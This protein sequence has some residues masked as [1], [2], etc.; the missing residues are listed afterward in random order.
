MTG[1]VRNQT[2]TELLRYDSLLFNIDRYVK[3]IACFMS[4]TFYFIQETLKN[5]LLRR[6]ASSVVDNIKLKIQ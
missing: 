4:N 5:M 2:S 1:P 3:M 6:D